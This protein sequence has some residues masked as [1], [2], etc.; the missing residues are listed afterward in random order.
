MTDR[1]KEVDVLV[2]G[3]GV[4]GGAVAWALAHASNVKNIAA[5]EQYAKPGSVNSNPR[6]NAQTSH[7]GSTE[8]NYSLAKALKVL[9]A[10]KML[11]AYLDARP[12][13][14]LWRKRHRMVLAVGDKEVGELEARFKEFAPHYPDIRLVYGD[15]LRQLEQKV[16]KGRD[17][18]EEVAAIV[19]SEGYIVDYQELAKKFLEDTLSRDPEMS[20]RFNTQVEMIARDSDGTHIVT[21]N[22]GVI[23]AKV[24]VVAAGAWSLYFAQMLGEGNDYGILPI[25]GSFYSA[26]KQLNGKVY[27][28]Q[29]EGLPFAA[30]HGDPDIL[31]MEDTR[32]GPTTK[33]LPMLE[34][35]NYKTAGGYFRIYLRSPLRGFF[36][37]MRILFGRGIL[38][39]EIKQWLY[40]LPWIGPA[41]F[42]RE[43]RTIVPSLRYCDITLRRGAGGIRPQIVDLKTGELIFG[44]VLIESPNA[45]FMTTPSP[46]ASVCL[47]NAKEIAQKV[48]CMLGGDAHF[49]EEAFRH[50]LTKER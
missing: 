1:M 39:Y 9:A 33:F 26:G 30:P 49:D 36:A 7:D 19:S 10:A 34:R 29:Q 6:N 18:E 40:D 27:R 47:A 8:T 32:F 15:E 23:R 22:K 2:V 12:S 24:L 28:V 48:V 37:A 14:T 44:N 21:T 45:L 31:D 41:L 16:M 5:V 38:G 43:L 4:S 13:L 25:A 17:P 35:F 42:L 46:G 20:V 50:A 3:W 11:R